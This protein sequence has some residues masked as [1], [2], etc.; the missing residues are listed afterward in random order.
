[1]P[2][3][4]DVRDQVGAGMREETEEEASALSRGGV[5]K[6]H[7]LEKVALGPWAEAATSLMMVRF[8]RSIAV[9]VLWLSVIKG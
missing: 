5:I 7:C 8:S 1:M 3:K 6:R 9:L 2:S 4:K